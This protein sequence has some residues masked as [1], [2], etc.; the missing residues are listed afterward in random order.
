MHLLQKLLSRMSDCRHSISGCP[1]TIGYISIFVLL[2]WP[3][4]Y[5][6][7]SRFRLEQYLADMRSWRAEM[8]KGSSM[9]HEVMEAEESMSVMDKVESKG[10]DDDDDHHDHDDDDHDH[11]DDDDVSFDDGIIYLSVFR[12]HFHNLYQHLHHQNYHQS[13]SPTYHNYHHHHHYHHHHF[14]SISYRTITGLEAQSLGLVLK[15][16]DSEVM[17]VMIYTSMYSKN[18]KMKLSSLS[19]IVYCC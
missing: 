6:C 12:I 9:I 17:I 10:V 2:L 14:C 16:F 7:C 19:C 11:D 18:R 15:C 1:M 3:G 5:C 13:S 4:C 8:A